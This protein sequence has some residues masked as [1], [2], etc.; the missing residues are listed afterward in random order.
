[1]GGEGSLIEILLSTTFAADS[2]N[3]EATLMFQNIAVVLDEAISEDTTLPQHLTKKFRDFVA[4]L[5]SVARRHFECHVRGSPRPPEP[6]SATQST[7]I[8]QQASNTTVLQAPTAKPKPTAKKLFADVVAAPSLAPAPKASRP[9]K[10]SR[11]KKPAQTSI[12]GKSAK[13]HEDNRLLV[14]VASGHPA[15]NISPYA[16]ME[17]LNNF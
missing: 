13:H 14:R 2:R 11:P 7:R 5:N 17:Q 3:R 12:K 9:K 10:I 6:Y 8:P 1:M 4:D 16:V 15:L